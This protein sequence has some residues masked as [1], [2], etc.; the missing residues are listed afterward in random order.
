MINY[1]KYRTLGFEM[2]Q[3][4]QEVAEDIINIMK[5]HIIISRFETT[6]RL[7]NITGGIHTHELHNVII[8][9]RWA[10]KID[11]PGQQAPPH[12]R[13]SVA[14]DHQRRSS[15]YPIN[16]SGEDGMGWKECCW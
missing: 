8:T 12:H 14:V 13:H 6:I 15:I 2:R 4:E 11:C 9:N 5:V 7:H 3:L 16:I 1:C 10:N